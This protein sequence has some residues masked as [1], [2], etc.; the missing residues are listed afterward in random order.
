[1]NFFICCICYGIIAGTIWLCG[2]FLR[3][4]FN[5]NFIITA[6]IDFIV[7]C[8][9]GFLFI[10]CVFAYNNGELRLYEILGF[11][12]GFAILLLSFGKIVAKLSKLIY[13]YIQK[14]DQRFN[15]KKEKTP[16]KKKERCSSS[17]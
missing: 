5:N 7:V 12:T 13:N 16:C 15:L 11:L 2:L 10:F 17:S 1:M 8:I 3:T 6:I 9:S 4:L 14:V